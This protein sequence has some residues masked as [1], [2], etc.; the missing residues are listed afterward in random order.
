MMK[1]CRRI[2]N[3][4]YS[5]IKYGNRFIS[6]MFNYGSSDHQLIELELSSFKYELHGEDSLFIHDNSFG[7]ADG[8]K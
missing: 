4:L 7:I 5:H 2:G 3:N 6:Q 1:P 8:G